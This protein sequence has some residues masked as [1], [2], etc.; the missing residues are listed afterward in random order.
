MDN[1]GLANEP[2]GK[3]TE[4]PEKVLK[5]FEKSL[6]PG[7]S[8]EFQLRAHEI[9][10]P[11]GATMVEIGHPWLVVTNQRLL[12]VAPGLTSFNVRSFKFDQIN[13]IDFRQGLMED[14]LVIN[15]IGVNEMWVF[16]KKLRE[17]SSKGA[18]ILQS[19]TSS[20]SA[21]KTSVSTAADPLTELKLRLARGEITL[22]EFNKLKDVM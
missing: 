2:P 11:N 9:R 21:A 5:K 12:M 15:G 6:M 19:R 4:M 14:L 18:Q 3:F 22:D 16:W 1:T 10:T 8:V 7:E 13:S 17:I 20:A